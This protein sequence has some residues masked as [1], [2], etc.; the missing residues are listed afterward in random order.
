MLVIESISLPASCKGSEVQSTFGEIVGMKPVVPVDNNHVNCAECD[1]STYLPDSIEVDGR[2]LCIDCAAKVDWYFCSECGEATDDF[3]CNDDGEYFCSS[4]YDD[5]YVKCEVCGNEVL[6]ENAHSSSSD[7]WYCSDCYYEHFCNCEHCGRETDNEDAHCSA[8]GDSY[9]ESCYSEL[10]VSCEECG[11]EVDRDSA[12]CAN[13]CCYCEGCYPGEGSQGNGWDY[14]KFRAGAFYKEIRSQRKFG[15]ELETFKCEG[16]HGLEGETCFDARADGS[17]KGMEFT[18][19]VLSS[20]EGLNAIRKFCKLANNQ[21]FEVDKDCGFH[22]HFDVKEL[23]SE[24][25]QSVAYAYLLTYDVWAAFV[26]SSRRDNHYCKKVQWGRN[27][28]ETLTNDYAWRKFSCET[29]RYVWCNLNAHYKHGTFEI[30]L[31]TATLDEEKVCNWVKAHTRFIDWAA[32]KSLDE[33]NEIFGHYEI[34]CWADQEDRAGRTAQA[35]KRKFR[36]LT[37]IWAD[38]ELSDFYGRRAIEFGTDLTP[39]RTVQ[40]V[41]V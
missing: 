33:I 28:L 3:A 2:T 1:G 32:S 19:P 17:I 10:Y 7:D 30:R 29:D 39:A 11:C 21:D 36:V 34:S 27:D 14:G 26:N 20:D 23:S 18:S 12:F 9:C 13:D 5:K 4:C 8:D 41:A 31:H 35:L 15:V 25:K 37:T 22:A 24:E 40:K 38:A 6:K 16:Y